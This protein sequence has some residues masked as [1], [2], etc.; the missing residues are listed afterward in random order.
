[1]VLTKTSMLCGSVFVSVEGE[2][3]PVEVILNREW[4]NHVVVY[5]N[6]LETGILYGP[7]NVVI[8]IPHIA[9]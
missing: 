5:E 2:L 9:G 6:V 8:I 4:L 3:L 1:M 7:G